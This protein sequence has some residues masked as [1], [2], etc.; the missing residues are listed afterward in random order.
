M[1]MTKLLRTKR[2]RASWVRRLLQTGVTVLGWMA[3][4]A[5]LLQAHGTASPDVLVPP[6]ATAGAMGFWLYWLIVL[7]PSHQAQNPEGAAHQEPRF[8]AIGGG[9]L[10]QSTD[11]SSEQRLRANDGPH[12][13][14][15]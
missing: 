7:W 11:R 15:A 6:L 10:I 9:R 4:T 1:T 8:A 13:D 3:G 12:R 14:S 2:Q 5:T